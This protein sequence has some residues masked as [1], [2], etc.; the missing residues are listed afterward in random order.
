MYLLFVVIITL[1]LNKQVLIK[2][3]FNC[4]NS[5]LFSNIFKTLY[6]LKLRDVVNPNTLQTGKS[7]NIL[8]KG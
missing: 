2:Q 8:K 6:W 7:I 5:T 4:K 3:H 1:L